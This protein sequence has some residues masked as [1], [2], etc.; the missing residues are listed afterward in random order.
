MIIWDKGFEY[1]ETW[2]VG[3]TQYWVLTLTVDI[4]TFTIILKVEP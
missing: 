4:D 3:D 1:E 2:G